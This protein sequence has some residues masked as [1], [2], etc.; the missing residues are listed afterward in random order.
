MPVESGVEVMGIYTSRNLADEAVS[1][2]IQKDTAL[3]KLALA[4]H[5]NYSI[6]EVQ[7][8]QPIRDWWNGGKPYVGQN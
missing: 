7:S 4:A 2:Q 5:N 3:G 8:N 1:A 6:E